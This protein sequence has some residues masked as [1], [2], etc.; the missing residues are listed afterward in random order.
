MG[1]TMRLRRREFLARMGALAGSTASGWAL[2][3]AG[4]GARDGRTPFTQ[5]DINAADL[6]MAGGQFTCVRTQESADGPFYYESSPQRRAIAEDR[7]G[8]PMRLGIRVIN[9]TSAARPG[10]GCVPL[11]GAIV[12][13]WQTDADGMYSNVGGDVQLEDTSGKKFLRGHYVT[14]ENGY[15]EFTSLVPGWE[16]VA[17]PR[18]SQAFVRTTHI[19]VKVFQERKIVTT[20]LYLPDPFLDELY[21]GAAPYRSHRQMKVPGLDRSFD[22]IRNV[23]DVI[24]QNDHSRPMGIKRE[25]NGIFAQATIGVMSMGALGY[26]SLFR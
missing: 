8:M 2:A 16:L 10:G 26:D 3:D 12:D 21:A 24:F 14:D 19:H 13:I 18:P 4:R 1:A 5:R 25:K 17:V 20:Q 11:A 22:R 15:V 7:L 6:A 9:A 23:Q